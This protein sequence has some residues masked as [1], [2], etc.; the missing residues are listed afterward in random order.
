[1]AGAGAGPG[2][3]PGIDFTSDGIE[4]KKNKQS[5]PGGVEHPVYSLKRHSQPRDIFL[6]NSGPVDDLP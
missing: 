5:E 1:M 4:R 6:Q 2:G 3:I